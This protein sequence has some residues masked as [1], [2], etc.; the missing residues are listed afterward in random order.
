MEYIETTYE[1]EEQA[2]VSP[3]ITLHRD[4]Y[5]MIELVKAGRLVIRQDN[6]TG[7]M[8]RVPLKQHKDTKQFRLRMQVN[9]ETVKIQ[10]FTSTEPKEIK[11]AYI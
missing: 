11:Y 2:W 7:D 8:P 5:L 6:G 3:V 10:I 4:I 1:E 9:P